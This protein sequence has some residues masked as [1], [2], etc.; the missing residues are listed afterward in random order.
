MVSQTY[1]RVVR[2][3]KYRQ[4]QTITGGQSVPNI[5]APYFERRPTNHN[6]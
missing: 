1:E 2:C 4:M 5:Y 3:A 6:L